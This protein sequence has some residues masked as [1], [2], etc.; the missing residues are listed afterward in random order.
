MILKSRLD[1]ADTRSIHKLL[2]VSPSLV[3]T[4]TLAKGL[5]ISAAMI[6]TL[7][8]AELIV[9]LIKR[10]I[11]PGTRFAVCLVVAAFSATVTELVLKICVPSAVEALGVYLPVLAVSC[12]VMLRLEKATEM[13]VSWALEDSVIT[14]GEFLLLMLATSFIR[15]L[16]GRGTLACGFDGNGGIKVF[17]GAPLPILAL[18]AGVLMLAAFGTAAIKAIER[19]KNKGGTK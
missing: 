16:L 17:P 19:S 10:M 6:L 12:V 7:L 18:P 8:I 15:E 4:D 13:P 14:G 11:Y 5:V 2:A 1:K 9:S 3:V